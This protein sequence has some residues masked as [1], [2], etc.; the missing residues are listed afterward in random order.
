MLVEKFVWRCNIALYYSV[1][2][3]DNKYKK[4]KKSTSE[5]SKNVLPKYL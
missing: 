4:Q 2:F 3:D 1:R 5:N